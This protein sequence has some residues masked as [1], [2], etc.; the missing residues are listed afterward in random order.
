MSPTR[1]TVGIA[2]GALLAPAFIALLASPVASADP[3]S[4]AVGTGGDLTYTFGPDTLTFD[5]TTG[6]FDN[7][8]DVSNFQFDFSVPVDGTAGAV[9][10]GAV[11]HQPFQVG[12]QD[13]DG[14]FN[15][16]FTGNTADFINP[17]WGLGELGGASTDVTSA[18]DPFGALL[19]DL[20]QLFGI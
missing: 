2:I 5:P 7:Y 6:G 12:V 16:E 20:G 4:A 17:V 8:F 19:V 15:Y 3:E 9:V 1:G 11:D 14:V 10:T 18:A 13:T